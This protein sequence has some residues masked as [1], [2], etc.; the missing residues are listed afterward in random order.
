[1]TGFVPLDA[2]LEIK[3]VGYSSLY[4]Q[5]V[6]WLRL[7]PAKFSPPFPDRQ[8][9][10]VYFD[11]YGYDAYDE[12]L[13][14][15]SDRTKVRY[16]WYG[17]SLVPDSGGLEVKRK[18]NYFGWK[19]RYDVNDLRY[20][21]TD[22]WYEIKHAIAD[23]VPP[24]A[25]HW[26]DFNPQ[27]ILINRYHRNYFLSDDGRVRATIDT[28]QEVWDQRYEAWPSFDHRANIADTMVIEFK[29][30]REDRPLASQM[31]QGIP[32]RVSRHSKYIVGTT[33]IQNF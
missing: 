17:S 12:N 11:T 28:R 20:D 13:S 3:F 32:L 30:S 26:L 8:V 27:P 18:R 14:G 21:E 23:K 5:L 9:N 10:N 7:H 33:A 15:A 2:R 16:R 31:L 25:R 4:D 1:M 29:F 19:L 22:G 24:E 6:S